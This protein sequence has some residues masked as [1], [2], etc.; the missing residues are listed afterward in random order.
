MQYAD[1]PFY[2]LSRQDLYDMLD[3]EPGEII[4]NDM[5]S[6][7]LRGVTFWE[8]GFKQLTANFPILSPKDLQGKKIRVMKSRI[9]MEQF[10]SFGA[11]PLAID[12][13][14]TKQVLMDGVVDGE[15]NPLIAIVSMGFYKVQ[16][17]LT[18]S[19]HGFLGYVLSFSEKSFLKLP[20]SVRTILIQTAKE[21]TPWERKE[22]QKK[23]K[24]LLQII[25]KAGVKL[26]RLDTKQRQE[27]AKLVEHIPKEYESVIGVD[28]ISKT[29]ELMYKKYGAS[30]D[31]IL[32]GI[33]ADVSVG[34]KLAG[35]EIKRGVEL[36]VAE[37]NAKGGV[38]AKPLKVILKDHKIMPSIG[39]EN[40]KE[41]AKNPHLVAI[42]GGKHSAVITE[43]IETIERLKVLYL[44]PWASAASL[45]DNEYEEN[46]IFRVSANNNL[47]SKF[48]LE[49]VMQK[50]KKPAILVEN[51]LWG[52][53]NMSSMKKYLNKLDM[54]FTTEII[55]NR[56][57]KSFE[58]MLRAIVESGADSIIIIADS[59][60]G[61]KILQ[62]LSKENKKLPIISH[63]G[64][65][66]G[67]FFQKNREI[68]SKVDLSFFQTYSVAQKEKTVSKKLLKEYKQR[69]KTEK[70]AINYAVAQAYDLTYMLALAI[71]KAGS[72]DGPKVKEALESLVNY[73]GVMKN[74]RSVFT[75]S[76]H[77]AL[78]ATDY[79]MAKFKSDG[80][81]VP[82]SRK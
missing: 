66:G 50:Y 36:A 27:F 12:F 16:S 53:E 34:G 4:L 52:R 21:V 10:E 30:L 28:I 57:Q 2:F 56:G 61:G 47:T 22:T 35:L 67:D 81:V 9:I 65:M 75:P 49:Y 72:T 58:K 32:I 43:E 14:R 41:F 70:M 40:I 71:E 6:I 77:D 15:E 8:N 11:I 29:E 13:H 73:Q 60:E 46:Y 51:S 62:A 33:D 1:L 54:K 37:I 69:Y 42:I 23:E 82:A 59:F 7:G 26:H 76:R 55:F 24:E 78:D 19:E 25:E 38:L 68:L 39:I 79:Y 18:L 48:I 63:W 3:G 31:H 17:D 20:N 80:T 74:Y 45:V 5:K 44:I 64:I